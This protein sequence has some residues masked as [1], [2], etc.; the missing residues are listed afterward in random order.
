MVLKP[1]ET[2]TVL[3]PASPALVPVIK[4][5]EVKKP[6]EQPK[7][8]LKPPQPDILFKLNK[9]NKR[10]AVHQTRSVVQDKKEAIQKERATAVLK[11]EWV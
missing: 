8:P 9:E 3:K 4:K 7:E 1:V 6:A 11:K 5:P 10:P 2:L